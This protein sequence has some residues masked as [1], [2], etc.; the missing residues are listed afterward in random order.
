MYKNLQKDKQETRVAA[1]GMRISDCI[2]R[3]AGVFTAQ[4]F[5]PFEY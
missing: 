4:H 5:V 2:T 1:L 3:E